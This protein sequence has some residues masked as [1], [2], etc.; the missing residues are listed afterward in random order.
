ME[1]LTRELADKVLEPVDNRYSPDN[2]PLKPL[3]LIPGNIE[4]KTYHRTAAW[5]AEVKTMTEEKPITTV[6]I[7]KRCYSPKWTNEDI[8]GA[9]AGETLRQYRNR[10]SKLKRVDDKVKQALI[11]SFLRAPRV[12][13]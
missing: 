12:T 5:W 11:D 7:Q 6:Q 4:G 3:K 2:L 1:R 8:V 9:F 10:V 13:L